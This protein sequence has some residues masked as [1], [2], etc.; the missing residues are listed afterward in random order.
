M[1][2]SA[3][4]SR[5]FGRL[6]QWSGRANAV[7]PNVKQE[8]P[9]RGFPAGFLIKSLAVTYSRTAAAA[10]SSALS[11]FTSVFGMGTGGSNSLMPPGKLANELISSAHRIWFVVEHLK[12]SMPQC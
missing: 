10:L 12:L 9:R 11:R 1:P 4:V 7:R 3:E 2:S 8:K 5:V 6:S